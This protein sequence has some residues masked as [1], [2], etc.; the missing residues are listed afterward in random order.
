[1]ARPIKTGLDYFSLDVDFYENMKTRKIMRACGPSSGSILTCLLC[2]IYRNKGY[3]ILW[4]ED[5]PFE[6]ADKVG[7]SEGAV[8]EVI[9]KALQVDFFDQERYE[10][11][12]ILTSA[13]IQNRYKAG[14]VKRQDVKIEDEFIVS[15]SKK[16]V[17]VSDNPVNGTGNTQSK[18]KETIVKERKRAN[19]L[20]VAGDN[21]AE[22]QQILKKEFKSLVEKLNGQERKVVWMGLLEFVRDKRPTFVEPYHELWNIFASNY[23]LV[24]IEAISDSR[25]SKFNTRIRHQS[26]DFPKILDKIR[27]SAHL[28][29]DNSQQWKVT[30]DW[31]FEND[32]NYL[33][34]IEGN[35]N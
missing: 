10:Q 21:E 34:I 18:V 3:Y 26:F 17:S 4:D 9:T 14:T 19:A 33:K 6:I 31:I 8:S 16:P 23:G 35:Y 7:V 30:F 15:E 28:K 20:V 29:G 1:M 22:T 12:R 25:R 11:F 32:K 2:T 13:E 24:K 5:L 27:T